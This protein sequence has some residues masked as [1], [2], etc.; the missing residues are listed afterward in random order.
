MQTNKKCIVLVGKVSQLS[1][2]FI[3]SKIYSGTMLF[4]DSVELKR[5]FLQYRLR[6]NLY[7]M[8]EVKIAEAK[9]IQ[10]GPLP[11]FL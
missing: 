6:G 5:A 1:T 11:A 7:G 4:E 9:L 10:N 3:A 2:P 8:H